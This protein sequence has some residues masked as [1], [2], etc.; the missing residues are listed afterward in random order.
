MLALPAGCAAPGETVSFKGPLP[1]TEADIAE[2]TQAIL[3]LG[4]DIDPDEA[5][6]AARVSYEATHE[7]AIQYQITD[8]ALVHNTKVNLGLKPR[9][10]CKH[11]AEDMEAR[12]LAEKFQTLSILRAI[13][14]LVG[15]DHS[16]AVISP[17]GG[18]IYDGI[19]VDPWRKGGT[20]TWI[21]TAEDTAWGWAPRLEVL[22]RRGLVRYTDGYESSQYLRGY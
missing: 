2:L 14:E 16:T 11:W 10:L 21:A 9:G 15:I 3:A 4:S 20:L 13:G 8:P 19:V 18:D 7:L 5:A 1:G 12:L 22:A 17:K 6:R